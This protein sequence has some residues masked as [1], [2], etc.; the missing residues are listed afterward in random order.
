M[1]AVAGSR[2]GIRAMSISPAPRPPRA[3]PRLR[4]VA[5][6]DVRT[7]PPLA[8]VAI[9]VLAAVAPPVAPPAVAPVAAPAGAPA[10]AL[11]VTPLGALRPHSSQ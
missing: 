6:E 3:E 2:S 4:P 10:A 9:P 11:A 7:E 5:R 1:T 8:T